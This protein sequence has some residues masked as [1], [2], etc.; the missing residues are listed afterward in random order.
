METATTIAITIPAACLQSLAN[1]LLVTETGAS[2]VHSKVHP[3]ERYPNHVVLIRF[4]CLLH[5]CREKVV[6]TSPA[7]A[8]TG[9][10]EEPEPW[11]ES[12]PRSSEQGPSRATGVL[13]FTGV[14]LRG[15][16]GGGGGS[17]VCCTFEG[18]PVPKQVV[19]VA[20]PPASVQV[21]PF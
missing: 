16:G 3:L 10:P 19:A 1:L 14:F 12:R 2:A 11:D 17:G 9:P 5:I 18:L 4:L 20:C 21:R 13:L 8:T 6:E 15:S 7:Q